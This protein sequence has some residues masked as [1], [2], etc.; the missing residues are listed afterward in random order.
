M[1]AE[2]CMATMHTPVT[3]CKNLN[4]VDSKLKVAIESNMLHASEESIIKCDNP[5]SAQAPLRT[6]RP[7]SRRAPLLLGAWT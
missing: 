5:L 1:R 4:I 3:E 2:S 7:C 6:I